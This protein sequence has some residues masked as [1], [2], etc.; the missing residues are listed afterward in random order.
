MTVVR[1][2][3]EFWVHAYLA[4]LRRDS[5]PA[6][7]AAIG[8]P[9]AGAVLVKLNRLDGSGRIFQR[10]Y[11]M[12]ADKWSWKM[13]DEG[14]DSDLENYLERQR[15]RDPDLWIVEV[16]DK[17]GRHMLDEPGMDG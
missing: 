15:A 10:T 4:R 7:V 3:S 11:D 12:G 16:E 13:L 8:D 5:I 17:C 9:D 6:F 1:L 2:A 14:P